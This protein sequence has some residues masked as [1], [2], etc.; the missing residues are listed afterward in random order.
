[1]RKQ[2]EIQ[3]VWLSIPQVTPTLQNVYVTKDQKRGGGAPSDSRRRKRWGMSISSGWLL[4]ESWNVTQKEIVK[5]TG[6]QLRYTGAEHWWLSA[7]GKWVF[8]PLFFQLFYRF[9]IFRIQNTWERVQQREAPG[10]SDCWSAWALG[11][12][13]LTF[14]F[15]FRKG[16]LPNT[17]S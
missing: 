14:Q 5:H 17:K 9:E 8:T 11:S 7:K 4:S 3:I 1:M 6:G 10:T 13:N 12:N 15:S 16:V 2:S